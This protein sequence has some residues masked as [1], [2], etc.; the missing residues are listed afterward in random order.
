MKTRGQTSIE[1][2][3]ITVVI[4][5]LSAFVISRYTSQQADIFVS[6][7]AR[8]GFISWV[9][10]N[11]TTNYQLIKVETSECIST[12]EIRVAIFVDP[13]PGTDLASMEISVQSSINNA[14]NSERTIQ[15]KVNPEPI[16]LNC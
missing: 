11:A 2:I 14:L 1:V 4:I 8:E 5:A 3:A 9:D 10:A 6:A 13:A 15:A 7:A 16:F 12:N